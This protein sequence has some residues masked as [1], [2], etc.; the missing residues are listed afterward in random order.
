[1][2]KLKKIMNF[3]NIYK[4]FENFDSRSDDYLGVLY[5]NIFHKFPRAYRIYYDQDGKLTYQDAV[6][7]FQE[8]RKNIVKKID[9]RKLLKNLLKDYQ[10][11]N[12]EVHYGQSQPD[13]FLNGSKIFAYSPYE[14]FI[15]GDYHYSN[16]NYSH[17]YNFL[18][19]ITLSEDGDMANYYEEIFCEPEDIEFIFDKLK[20]YFEGSVKEEK[21]DFGI[22]SMDQ[23]NNIFTTTYDYKKVDVDINTNYNDDFIPAYNKLCSIIEDEDK[24]GLI[25]LYGEP[26]TG[27]S[28]IIKHLIGKY[29]DKEFVFIDDQLIANAPPE[30]MLSYFLESQ[31]TIFILEDCENALKTRDKGHNPVMPTLLNLTDGIIADV[32]GIKLICTFN[33]NLNEI[34]KALLRKGRLSLKYEF[35]KLDAEKASKLL[36]AIQTTPLSL[37]DI[38]YYKKENDFSK[39]AVKKIGF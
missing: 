34:D 29:P 25:L 18:I 31:N 12:Q 7:S 20:G 9:S 10:K 32:L 16:S 5:I 35:K 21:V 11:Y 6:D 27:K 33:T 13:H 23:C 15:L 14:Y 39:K 22:A 37:A 38:Y 1:M 36:G 17:F 28:T 24:P 2:D 4:V 19:N 8:P 26:G 30:K 3:D